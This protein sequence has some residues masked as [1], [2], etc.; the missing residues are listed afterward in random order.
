MILKTCILRHLFYDVHI[1]TA[2]TLPSQLK[3]TARSLL[4]N[5]QYSH[6]YYTTYPL[7]AHYT[8]HTYYFYTYV[9][10]PPHQNSSQFTTFIKIKIKH[11]F[12]ASCLCEENPNLTTSPR[13]FGGHQGGVIV[14]LNS[15]SR[16]HDVPLSSNYITCQPFNLP[17][18][19]LNI[20]AHYKI[21]HSSIPSLRI[22]FIILK[23]GV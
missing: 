9:Y 12:T 13:Q 10:S 21:A 14:I 6:P 7:S 11:V 2:Q 23:C 8:Q 15:E 19:L 4:P 16:S 18:T 1:N 3:N 22:S 20:P 17:L 5:V